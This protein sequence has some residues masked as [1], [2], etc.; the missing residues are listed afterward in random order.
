MMIVA[1]PDEHSLDATAI[2][3]LVLAIAVAYSAAI[4]H[5]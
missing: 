4:S 2:R 3:L 5:Q 1:G